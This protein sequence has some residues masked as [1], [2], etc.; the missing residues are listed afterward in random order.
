MHSIGILKFLASIGCVFRFS[1]FFFTRTGTALFTRLLLLCRAFRLLDM[2]YQSRRFRIIF[3]TITHVI[4]VIF[5][6]RKQKTS[7]LRI[8]WR[9]FA[10]FLFISILTPW[11]PSGFLTE[12]CYLCWLWHVCSHF[13]MLTFSFVFLWQWACL[14]CNFIFLVSLEWYANVSIL[15]LSVSSVLFSSTSMSYLSYFLLPALMNEFSVKLS[16]LIL[17]CVS[18]SG[19]FP[20][21]L[22]LWFAPILSYPCL[23]SGVSAASLTVTRALPSTTR[24]LVKRTTM[25]V[26][27]REHRERT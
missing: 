9:E 21:F 15:L 2:L 23:V 8:D 20:L 24:P 18:F 10:Q 25:F 7:E 17:L 6:L 13:I 22:D 26:W 27:Q 11:F 4:P 12:C 5:N 19:L 1:P 16:A 14:L 3:N